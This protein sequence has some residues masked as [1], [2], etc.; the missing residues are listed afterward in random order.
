M[1]LTIAIAM[2]AAGCGGPGDPD[3]QLSAACDRQREEVAEEESG[4]PTAKSTSERLEGVTL[5]ECAGQQVRLVD[6][7]APAKDAPAD[8]EGSMDAPEDAPADETEPAAEEAPAKLDPA[9]RELFISS[10]GGCHMLS[11]AG[12]SSAV[13]PNLDE[14]KMD[15]ATIEMQI[16]NGAG[17]MPAGL[18]EGAEATSVAEYVAAAA[19]AG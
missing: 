5:V 6:G 8:K 10:C 7:D 4:T 16:I 17:A 18:L 11:D 2:F 9:A 14:T 12:T 15:A 19:A 13:G 1:L 3:K